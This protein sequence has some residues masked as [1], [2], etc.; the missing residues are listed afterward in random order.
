[1][2]TRVGRGVSFIGDLVHVWGEGLLPGRL[3]EVVAYPA[4]REILLTL[5]KEKVKRTTDQAAVSRLGW[6]LP[7]MM[8]SVG[9]F[10]K[11]LGANTNLFPLRVKTPSLLMAYNPNLCV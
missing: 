4:V 3:H 7:N 8:V 1:M 2:Y 9:S 10:S 5:A 6:V 11:E